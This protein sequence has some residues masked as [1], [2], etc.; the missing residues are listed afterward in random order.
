M[1]KRLGF[2]VVLL[3]IVGSWIG[4]AGAQI[5]LTFLENHNA[6]SIPN[7][8]PAPFQHQPDLDNLQI[9]TLVRSGG[10]RY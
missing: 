4:N 3:L 7:D 2:A 10:E 8:E 1:K 6:F 5:E 9:K